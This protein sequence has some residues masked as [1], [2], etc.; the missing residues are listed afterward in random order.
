MAVAIVALTGYREDTEGPA[1]ELLESDNSPATDT[2]C[3]SV[4][5]ETCLTPLWI[6]RW[7]IG[8]L[9]F[10]SLFASSPIRGAWGCRLFSLSACTVIHVPAIILKMVV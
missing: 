6:G 1:V 9:D 3:R 5:P 10:R 4:E 7:L 8:L 2:Y